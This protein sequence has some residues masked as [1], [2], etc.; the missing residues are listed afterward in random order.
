MAIRTWT[1]PAVKPCAGGFENA[2]QPVDFT[3]AEVIGTIWPRAGMERIQPVR[4]ALALFA[5]SRMAGGPTHRNPEVSPWRPLA[6]EYA[7]HL[8]TI[9]PLLAS[10]MWDR[11]EVAAAPAF[12]HCPRFNAVA[13]AD[14]VVTLKG[15]DQLAVLMLQTGPMEPAA[16]L[17]EM[18]AAV[19]ML[20]D[21][22]G[23]LIERSFWL[24]A[25]PG[26]LTIEA[27]DTAAAVMAWVDA[28]ATFR[29]MLQQ[30]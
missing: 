4:K 23:R 12:L 19:T 27:V 1:P 25:A 26:K 9:E 7:P 5:R 13:V 6:P 21:S 14:L 8:A 29:W 3:A 18:G 22:S 10:A 2:G 17:A 11:L 24:Q 20:G 30:H 16:A 15:E 28:C